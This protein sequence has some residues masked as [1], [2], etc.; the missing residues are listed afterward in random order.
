MDT[1]FA[2]GGAVMVVERRR[3]LQEARELRDRSKRVRMLL[4]SDRQNRKRLLETGVN[5]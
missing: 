3:L 2:Q 1:Q 4:R 5:M